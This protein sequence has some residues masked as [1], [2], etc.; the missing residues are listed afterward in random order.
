MRYFITGATGFIGGHVADQLRAAGH[1]VIALVRNPQQAP[2]LA[3]KGI[4]LAQGDVTNKASLRAA[5][6]GCDGIFHIAGWYKVG[7]KDKSQAVAV[8]VDGTRNVLEAMRELGIAKGVYTS[9]LAVNSDTHGKRVDEGYQ[10]NGTHLSEYDRTKAEAHAIAKQL[11]AE[12]LPLVIVQPGMVYGPGDLGPTHDLLV[13]FLKRALPM[14]PQGTAFC[15]AHVEDVARGHI[16]AMERGKLG[17]SY[18]LAGP[19]HTLI[20]ALKLAEQ[21]SG[22]RAPAL[23]APPCMLRMMSAMMSLVERV[24]PVPDNY[25]SEYLR[26]SAGVT[27]IADNTKAR[28]QLGWTPRSLEDGLAETLRYEMQKLGMT[29]AG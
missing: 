7:V 2:G 28:D 16:L 19:V 18:F 26:V 4:Q 27:Y 1:Q 12:G 3:A 5:M 11:I 21:L 17:E 29:A 15:W 25:S 6:S 9:T 13:Q 23:S 24:V 20:A 8:N 14:A 10:F 22:V